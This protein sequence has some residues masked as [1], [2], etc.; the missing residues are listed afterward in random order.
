MKDLI[1][2]IMLI[3]IGVYFIAEYFKMDYEYVFAPLRMELESA[4]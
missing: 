3:H 2:L 4:Q 1:F